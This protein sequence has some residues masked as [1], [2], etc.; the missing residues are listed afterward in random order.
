MRYETARSIRFNTWAA[1]AACLVSAALATAAAFQHVTDKM[2]LTAAE[3][4]PNWLT[5]YLKFNFLPG[6]KMNGRAAAYLQAV[7]RTDVQTEY[8]YALKFALVW[9]P[10]GTAALVL[11][12]FLIGHTHSQNRKRD[13]DRPSSNF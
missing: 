11:I 12:L 8:I 9:V 7:A 6:G 3:H 4:F 5:T 13:R 1:V 2:S 10:A